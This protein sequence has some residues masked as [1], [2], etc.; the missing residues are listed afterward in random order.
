MEIKLK[1]IIC[2]IIYSI[3]ILGLVF[4]WNSWEVTIIS[5]FANFSCVLVFMH[6]FFLLLEN[7]DK[8]IWRL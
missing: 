1:H 5:F 8:I 4:G 3:A 2:G 6:L 7:W